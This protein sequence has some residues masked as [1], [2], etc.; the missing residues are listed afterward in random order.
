M[1]VRACVNAFTYTVSH[2]GADCGECGC[3]WK[4]H[5]SPG[6]L[7]CPIQ[8]LV[9]SRAPR[10]KEIVRLGLGWKT[11][12]NGQPTPRPGVL[13]RGQVEVGAAVLFAGLVCYD[14]L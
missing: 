6:N 4:P 5:E 9:R 14:L 13:L 8:V 3:A 1:C 7:H 10:A 11:V 12:L 2:R